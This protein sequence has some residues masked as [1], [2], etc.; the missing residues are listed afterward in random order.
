MVGRI[1]ANY[2][3]LA[4]KIAAR[5]DNKTVIFHTDPLQ[6]KVYMFLRLKT[7]RGPEFPPTCRFNG[8]IG[9]L[10]QDGIFGKGI[11]E[12]SQVFPRFSSYP[13]KPSSGIA[14]QA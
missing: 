2:R 13:T 5:N 14:A 9:R 7:A 3:K 11:I 4:A 1:Q 6:G 8:V 12:P 10:L